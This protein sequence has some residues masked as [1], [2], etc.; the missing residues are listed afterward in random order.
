MTDAGLNPARDLGPRI[1]AYFVG[2]KNIAFTM[3]AFIVYVLAP[4]IGGGLSAIFFTKV[5]EPM[6]NSKNSCGCN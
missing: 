5:I 6:Q 3:D 1:V 2:W 4:L